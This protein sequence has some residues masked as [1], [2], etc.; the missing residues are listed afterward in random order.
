MEKIEEQLTDILPPSQRSTAKHRILVTYS[1]PN[2][3]MVTKRKEKQ[4]TH[5]RV[6]ATDKRGNSVYKAE[7]EELA[8]KHMKKKGYRVHEV[9]H[10]GLV[11]EA[12][13]TSGV[14]EKAQEN[15][16]SADS[17]KKQGDMFTH[18]M[19]M[20]D[21]HENMSQ[22]HSEEG[23]HNMADIH[24]EKAEQHHEKAMHMK[25]GRDA[26]QRDEYSSK[27]GVA[28]ADKHSIIGK[29]QRGHE[30]KKKV[31]TSFADIGKA[32]KQGDH[33]AASKAFRKHERYANLERPGTWTK[34][35]EEGVTEETL[36]EYGDTPKGQK[37]LTKVQKRAV[38]RVTSKKADTDPKYA[39]KN[40]D[41]ANRAWDRMGENV[42]EG[43]D[44]YQR[45]KYSSKQGFG[46]RHR[47]DD[48][49]HTPDPTTTTHRVGF[50]VSKDG[51]EKHHR[52]VTISNSRKSPEEAK[53]AARAHLE[54]QGY[55]IHEEVMYEGKVKGADGKACWKGYR[56]A[57]TENGKDKCVPVSEAETYDY[58]MQ[59]AQSAEKRGDM[60]SK[61]LHLKRAQAASNE[62]LGMKEE[63]VGFNDWL[64]GNTVKTESVFQ[65][66]ARLRLADA[67]R[68]EQEKREAEE[69]RREKKEPE[70]KSEKNDKD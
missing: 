48:E 53:S 39:K 17:A 3:T 46:R 52:T 37:M 27:Q 36:K 12:K 58:H 41:T 43:R 19:H 38:D 21:H 60:K 65:S 34:V 44:A 33:T 30:L 66:K 50:H 69:A 11:N 14:Y 63:V 9:T 4:Q 32:Q 68:K 25:E 28:E 10:V 51:G 64:S 40:Q 55:K 61:V 56:Y 45:D 29:I 26:Y 23:R 7:A 54:K 31:D 62:R 24:A 20:A 16:Q 67:L 57:G 47:E 42:E 6:P 8:K 13:S 70:E 5:V 49:Y 2:H 59:R 22:W 1:S 18:H 15:K 35:D